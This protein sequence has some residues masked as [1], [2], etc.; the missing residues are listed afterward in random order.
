MRSFGYRSNQRLRSESQATVNACSRPRAAREVLLQW[1]DG[2]GV[3]YAEIGRLAVRAVSI[4]PIA[5]IALEEFGFGAA[6]RKAR[7]GEI[8]EHIRGVRVLHRAIMMRAAPSLVLGRVTGGT[9]RFVDECSGLRRQVSCRCD[10][11]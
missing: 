10:R 5:A 8:A 7:A 11:A 4:D 3:R 6:M 2:E 9:A 1:I